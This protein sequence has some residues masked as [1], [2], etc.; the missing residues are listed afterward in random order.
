MRITK[1][2]LRKIIKEELDATLKEGW[3]PFGKKDKAG[4]ESPSATETAPQEEK[5]GK[6]FEWKCSD[7]GDCAVMAFKGSKWPYSMRKRFPNG[8]NLSIFTDPKRAGQ[9]KPI[10]A[11]VQTTGQDSKALIGETP[12]WTRW[13]GSFDI[14]E[15]YLHFL[16]A[17][18]SYDRFAKALHGDLAASNSDNVDWRR[19]WGS[20]P[21][22]VE[23]TMF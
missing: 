9:H 5:R 17:D 22:D 8:L 11:R 20:L 14:A 3:W 1:S 23:K 4:T 13:F 15:E 7:N 21:P 2:S 18:G 6:Y 16:L 12:D 10:A 19:A